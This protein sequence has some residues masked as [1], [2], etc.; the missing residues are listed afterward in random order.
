MISLKFDA[1]GGAE[2]KFV[3]K[4][5]LVQLHWVSAKLPQH[6]MICP[7]SFHGGATC[8]LC[9]ASMEATSS[10]HPLISPQNRAFSS[11]RL[12]SMVWDIKHKG[13]R[14]WMTTRSVIAN[15]YAKMRPLG[16][17][18]P[19]MEAGRAADVLVQRIGNVY[20]IV[21]RP[22]TVGM[23]R[24]SKRIPD[25]AKHVST[26]RDSVWASISNPYEVQMVYARKE[27]ETLETSIPPTTPRVEKPAPRI[28]KT[29]DP[30]DML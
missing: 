25:L 13:F 5:A 2:I 12:V 4:P 3:G 18:G 27:G 6:K 9:K 28:L 16:I 22:E 10:S 20:D 29:N 14:A 11:E 23:I 24:H 1:S 19:D 15:V 30:W 21:I 8:L 7:E 26:Y 17:S